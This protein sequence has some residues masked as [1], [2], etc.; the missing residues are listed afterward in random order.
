VCLFVAVAAAVLVATDSIAAEGNLPEGWRAIVHGAAVHGANGLYFD[1]HNRLH[2][3]AVFG[4]EIA[5]IDPKSGELLD[6]IG[7]DRGVEGPDDLFI[8]DDGSIY[9][10]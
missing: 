7:P 2:V 6:R 5:V 3:A 10:T 9:Q 8:R 4:R 1:A